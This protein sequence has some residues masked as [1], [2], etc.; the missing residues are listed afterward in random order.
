MVLLRGIELTC[1]TA[2][3]GW[4]DVLVHG[5][6]SELD[7]DPADETTYPDLPDAMA[8]VADHGGVAYVAHP[9]WSGVPMDGLPAIVGVEGYNAGCEIENGRGL[10]TVHW[11]MLL[12]AGRSCF[13][14]ACD[15]TH[16]GASTR[17][18]PGRWRAWPS[19]P[20]RRSWKRFARAPAT[21]RPGPGWGRSS[22]PPPA[23]W[24]A[25]APAGR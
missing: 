22:P 8:F 17:A 19:P 3:G 21:P 4:V 24:C 5:L 1:R 6:D 23:F 7:V 10:S 16:Y 13:A 20:R 14:I 15:D 12:D 9:Y 25:A 18:T 11:D 2:K